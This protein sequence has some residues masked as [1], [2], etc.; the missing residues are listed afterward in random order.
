MYGLHGET[1]LPELEL[2]HWEGYRRSRPVHIGNGAADQFQLEIF[3]EFLNM[4]YELARRGEELEPEIWDFLARVADHV[5]E[6]WEKPDHGIWEMRGPTRHFTY[7]KVMAWVAFDR[8]IH[9][10]RGY[11]L[12]GDVEKWRRGRERVR[13]A[14]LE[15]GYDRKLGAFVQAFGAADL[16]ASNLRIPLM[17]FLPFDDPRVQ[18]TIDRTLEQLT[19]NG[20]VYRYRVDDGLP[21]KE[22]TFGLCTFW[23]VDAL[24]L[25]GRLEEAEKIFA[26]IARHVNHVGLFAEQIDAAS[27]AFL[28]NFPQAFTHI[29][30]INSVLNLAWARGRPIPEHG[31]IGT[32]EHREEV[33]RESGPT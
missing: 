3:D 22:G 13:Q 19:E 33:G 26:S 14:V 7:S 24:A 25:S 21:G 31:L 2:P 8:A 32:P 29:G 18:G 4:G 16:D 6:V 11:G 10:A 30:L 23:L 27:G 15:N 17:E 12:K 28:G 20:L 9:L 1:E 5:D